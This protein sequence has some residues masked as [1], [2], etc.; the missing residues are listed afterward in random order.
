[1]KSIP[2]YGDTAT[3]RRQCA[4]Q[5]YIK[6]KAGYVN[7]FATVLMAVAFS[8]H[9]MYADLLDG[10]LAVVTFVGKRPDRIVNPGIVHAFISSPVK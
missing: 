7:S 1:M 3:A 2:A 5:T 6:Y 4:Q 8:L 9:A 10:G